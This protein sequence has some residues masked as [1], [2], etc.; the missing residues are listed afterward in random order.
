MNQYGEGIIIKKMII[1]NIILFLTVICSKIW[2]VA[3][4]NKIKHLEG[5][6]ADFFTL[7]LRVSNDCLFSIADFSA[8]IILFGLFINLFFLYRLY[9]SSRIAQ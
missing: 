6:G 7:C 1:T 5:I 3:E 2:Y 8:Y 9:R 4:I